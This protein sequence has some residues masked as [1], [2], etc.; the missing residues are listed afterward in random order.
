MTDPVERIRGY[1][2]ELKALRRDLHA[3]PE[4][5]FAET[6]TASLVAAKLEGWGIEVHRGLAKT[7]V[8]GTLHAGS[9]QRAIALRA[10][11]DALHIREENA[12]AH[13]SVYDGRMH[14]CGHDGH[15][16]M[17]L[18][19]AKYL[20]ETKC[21]DGT[22]HF[23]FQPAEENEGGGRVMVAEGLF[24]KFPCEAVYGMHNTC[25]ASRSAG[26]SPCRG[27]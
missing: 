2:A 24:D 9:A 12:F 13:R 11:L 21:F 10:D 5:A 18:G 14:A 25:P 27:P 7:G 6:R 20:A 1:S 17:L 26:S 22:V 4:L 15:T 23:I 16:A 8:V 19:P 3:H